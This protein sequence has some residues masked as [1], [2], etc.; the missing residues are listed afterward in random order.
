MKINR[1]D[2][3]VIGLSGRFPGAA[4]T[5]EFWDGLCAGRDAIRAL[6]DQALRAAGVA[7]AEL[8]DPDYVKAGAPLDGVELFDAGLFK[9]SPLEAE[10]MD[11]QIRLLL[12]C[13]WET[14]EDAGYGG[15]EPRRIGVFA[16]AGG[17][18][19]SYFSHFVN[20]LG[21]FEKITA[22]PTHLGND[23]DFL[24]TYLS[25]KLNLTGPSM[26]VQTACST[27]LVALHQ[28][29]LSLMAGECDMALAGG[30]SVRVPNGHGYRYKDGYI[31]SRSGRVRSFDA[32]ADG[33]VFG[34]GM[35]LVLIKRL[36]D[37]LR[38]GDPVRAVIKGSAI[39]NDGKGKMSYAASSARGQIACIRAALA[40]ACVEAG[41]IGLVEAHGTGTAMGDPEE[42]KALSAAFREDTDAKGYCALGAVKAN[43][44][45]LEAAAGIVGF[46]KAALAVERGV[47]PPLLHFQQA[48]PRIK[49][50]ATPFFVNTR[51]QPWRQKGPRRAAVN[52][53]GV[54]GT[55]AF[56]VLEQAPA[57]KPAAKRRA[58]A[59][60]ALVPIS[61]RSEDSLREYAARLAKFIAR[62]QADKTPLD[63]AE[64]ACTLQTG[65]E[66]LAQRAAFAVSS[67]AQ[68]RERLDAFA[69]GGEG[70]AAADLPAPAAQWLAEGSADWDSL[71]PAGRPRRIGLPTYVFARE[72]HWIDETPAAPARSMLHPLLHAN[73]SD[74]AEVRYSSLFHGDEF[75][76]RD[77]RVR[78]GEEQASLVLPGVAYL[79][80]AR[81]ALAQAGSGAQ[82][83]ELRDVVWLQPATVSGERRLD[84]ALI[85]HG[86]GRVDFETYGEPDTIHCQGRATA[87]A[88]AA[89]P[90][91]DLDAARSA[92]AQ[93]RWD[94]DAVYAA[95]AAMGLDYGPAHRPIAE[96]QR[97]SGE[98]LA[99]LRLPAAQEADAGQFGLHPSLLDGALQ[100]ATWLLIDPDDAP[101]RPLV[102]FALTSLRQYSALPRELYV[103]ARRAAGEGGALDLDLCDSD[104]AVCASLRG[105]LARPF[106]KSAHSSLRAT[107]VWQEATAQP[108]PAREALRTLICGLPQID[109]A[110]IDPQAQ[111]VALDPQDDQAQRYTALAQHC[112]AELKAVLSARPRSEAAFQVV[113]P[114]RVEDALLLGL[115][116]M[117]LSAGAENPR[118]RAQLIAVDPAIDAPALAALL[119]R[120]RESAYEPLLRLRAGRREAARWQLLPEAADAGA[121][122]ALA[123]KH[124]GTYLIT[125]GLGG[126]G[127][128]FARD[129]LRRCPGV[130][131]L[132]AGRASA[133][134]VR[135]SPRQAALDALR[136][137]GLQVEYVQLDLDD[138]SALRERLHALAARYGRIDG[139]VHSAGA[140]AD[141]L[142][143]T[144]P[145]D[146]LDAVLAPK[147]R[148][149]FNLDA[150]SADLD[151]DFLALFSS[152]S[153]ALGNAGQA[154]YAAA[155]G[156]LDEF[157]GQ[158]NRLAAAGARRGHT[159]AIAWP[160]WREGGMRLDADGEAALSA[161]TGVRPLRS[162]TGLRLFHRS[163]AEGRERV[164]VMDG[165]TAR[166]RAAL[167]LD[168]APAR[169]AAMVDASAIVATTPADDLHALAQR[170]LCERM[171]G[172]LKLPAQ[173]LDPAAPLED[174]GIDSILALDLTRLLEASFGALPRTLFFEYLSI[175]ELAGYFAREHADTL[176]RLDAGGAAQAPAAT[177]TQP[178]PSESAS[179]PS[180]ASLRRPA[181]RAAADA[182]GA[183]RYADEPIAIVGLSGRY[184]QAR[185]LD[186]FWRNLRDGRDCIEE[187]PASRWNWRDYYSED[188]SVPGRHYSKWG[189]FIEGVDEFDARFFNI[190]PIEAELLDP[191]ER[192]FLEHAWMAIEDAGLTRAALQI[193]AGDARAT[194]ELAGQVGVYAGVMYGEYQLI[195]VENSL[196]G[197][198][199]GFASNPA[200]V[201]NR[202]SYA[203][204]LHGPSMT[205]DTMCSSSLSA[206]HL[207]CQDLKL[208]RTDAA[209]AGGVNVT[210]HPNKYL[211]LSAGQFISGDGH[212]QSFGEGGD[213]YIPG[214]GVG[215]VVLKRLSDAQRDGNR[216]YGLIRGSALSH[217]GKT[218]G[219]TVPNPQAQ[220]S[221][222]RQA[223]RE[224]G[225]PARRIGYVEAHGTGT[226]LGDPIEIAAL[227]K[228]F[229]ESSGDSGFCLIGSAKSNIGHCEAAA[230]IA[231]LT[232]VLLQLQHGQIVP[233]LHSAQLNPHI[234]FAATPFVVNQGLREWPAPQHEGRALPRVAGISS[235]GAGGSN[236]HLIV[237]EYLAPVS[238]PIAD[239][240]QML[241]LSARTAEQ[242]R[243][244]AAD[245]LAWLEQPGREVVLADLAYTLQS[246]REA[247][248]ERLA[249]VADSP[250]QLRERL[251]AWLD[252]DERGVY[253]G[254]AKASRERLAEALNGLDL[255]AELPQWRER[256][257]HAAPLRLWALGLELDWAALRPLGAATRHMLALPA[258][259]FARQRHW[260]EPVAAEKAAA[261]V[262]ALHPLLHSNE[263][264]I[265]RCAY[266]ARFEGNEFFL[267][268]RALSEAACVE[269][270]RAAVA[271]ALAPS[272]PGLQL[273][274]RELAWAQPRQAPADGR[275]RISLFEPRG[276]RVRFEIHSGEGV[277]EVVHCQG[278]AVYAEAVQA[279]PITPGSGELTL[280]AVLAD[281]LGD[282]LLHPSLLQA[283]FA[284]ASMQAPLKLDSLSV[285]GAAATPSRLALRA[286]V[287]DAQAFDLDLCAADGRVWA[288]LRG[289]RFAATAAQPDS[290]APAYA[291]TS[292]AAAPSVAFATTAKAAPRRIAFAAAA[293]VAFITNT[294]DTA[295]AGL[296][297]PREIALASA[298][299][300]AGWPASTTAKPRV[301]L[302]EAGANAVASAPQP[303]SRED[304]ALFDEGQGV[305]VL[306][307]QGG[308][309]DAEAAAT[310]TQALRA[311][312][313]EPSLKTLLVLA[314][315]GALAGGA[316][317]VH[318]AALD[319]GLYRAAAEFPY[320]LIAALRGDADGPG[321]LFATLADVL[322]CAEQGRYA[323]ASSERRLPPRFARDLA[324]LRFGRALADDLLLRP[325]GARGSEL[326]QAGWTCSVLA[327]DAVEAQARAVAGDLAAKSASA[328]GLLKQELAAPLLEAVCALAPVDAA[329]VTS[330][331]ELATTAAVELPAAA[332]G[333]RA[334]SL[335]A[336]V[337][338]IEV[339]AQAGAAWA[340]EVR[341][342]LAVLAT[343]AGCRGIVLACADALPAPAEE[344]GR[345]A[346]LQALAE[347]LAALDCPVVAA[348]P[349]GADGAA[350]LAALLCDGVVYAQDAA[351]NAQ[352]LFD[353][354]ALAAP[355]LSVF[356]A[357]L[358][359]AP[360]RRLLLGGL[361]L[362]GAALAR[363]AQAVRVSPAS[364][365]IVEAGRLAAEL[366]QWPREELALW[367]RTEPSPFAQAAM[368]T[369]AD[370][371]TGDTAAPATGAID[372]DSQAI[373]AQWR[374]GGVLEIG[375][376]DRQSRN[377]FSPEFSRG[378]RAAFAHAES[379]AC[380][381]VVLGGFERYFAAGGTRE[382]L[383]AIHQGRAR[384]TDDK[385]FELPLRCPVPVI[386]AMQGH[387]VG[388][389]WALGMYADVALF[390]SES[391]YFSPY[392]GY[393]FTPGAGSTLLFAQRIGRDLAR[394][395]LLSAREYAGD[396][397]IARGLRQPLSARAQTVAEALALA[398]CIA[399]L[400]RA[401]LIALKRDWN[402]AL[403][404]GLEQAYA[405]ELAMH[406]RTFVGRADTLALIERSFVAPGEAT[407][408]PAAPAP[409]VAAAPLALADIVA[410]L[411][412]SLAHELRL[413]E[414]EIG[415]DEEF[416][417]LGLDSITGVTWIRRV[418][419]RYGTA[420]EAIQVYS[421]PTLERL[422]RHVQ[423]LAVAAPA[424]TSAPAPA[425]ASENNRIA[426]ADVAATLR[427]LLAEELRLSEQD[428][429]ADEP[430]VDL[431]LDSIT[432]VTWVRR[433]NERY[434]TAIEAVQV[435][436]HPNLAR[437][438]AFVA[439]K[440]GAAALPAEPVSMPA[441]PPA[442]IAANTQP[443]VEP[444]RVV[445]TAQRHHARRTTA[446]TA[447]AIAVIGMS[448][449]F[450]QARDLEQFW[451]NL[452]NARDCIAEVPAQRWDLA[453]YYQPG[454]AVPGKT[455][456]RW[457][458]A[459]EDYDRFDPAFF[460][461][462]PREARSMDPQQRLFLQACWHGIEHAGYNPKALAGSNCGVFVGCAAGDYHQLS[463]RE[464]LSG[465][466][467]TG[468]AP[469]ILAARISYFLDLHGPSLAVDT[470]CSSSLVALANACDSLASGA[471][472]LALAG[473]V[474]VMAGPGMHIMTAQVGMLG[475]GGRC[476]TFDAAADGIALGE[477][478]GV[479]VL[480]R[481]ADAERDGDCIHGVIEAW[482]VNQDGRS[483]GITA[484][485]ADAQARL[486]GDVYRRFG[487]DPAGIQ[488]VE[489]HGTGTALGDPIEVAALKTAFA[490]HTARSG[491]CALGSV[492]SNIGHCLSAAG[493]S[494]VLKLLLAL[495]HRQLPPTLH[496]SSLNPHI[497]LDGSPFYVNDRLREWNVEAGV[498][499][500]AAINAF[501]F[502]GTNAHAVISEYQPR[503]ADVPARGAVLAPLSAAT[504]EQLR[505]KAREL[506][507]RVEVGVEDLAS[508]AYTLQVGRE[509]MGERAAVVASDAA[510]LARGLRALAESDDPAALRTAGVLRGRAGTDKDTLA[511]FAAEPDFQR[512]LERW[513]DGGELA[514]L[515]E[516]WVKGLALD[517]PRFHAAGAPQRMALPLHPFARER[518]WIEAEDEAAVPAAT[519]AMAEPV[520]APAAAQPVRPV[521]SE[522]VADAAHNDAAAL[523][524]LQAQLR[525]SLAEA[526]FMRAAE[527]GLDKPFNELGLDSIVGVEWVKA[528]NQQ[529]GCELS[530]TRIYDYPSVRALAAY[531]HTAAP[532]AKTV[533]VAP[534]APV[535]AT[536]RMAPAA[537]REELR[538]SLAE[539]LFMRPA[540]IGWN[541][542]F[543]ELGLDSIVGVEWV[544][545]I[546]RRYG[547]VL[548]ATRVYDYP[549]ID[550]LAA[551]L[552]EQTGAAGVA[553]VVE[554]PAA[555]APAA[556]P[557]LE[558]RAADELQRELR[559]SLAE[560]LYMRP[561]D[562]GLDKS[563]TELGLDSIVGVEWM[564]QVNQRYGTQIAALRV[565]DYPSVRSLAAHL[566]EHLPAAPAAALR[567]HTPARSAEATADLF[568]PL[569][570][571]AAPQSDYFGAGERSGD[572]AVDGELSLLYR[573]VP[574]RNV[575]LREHVVFGRHLLPT[576]A[577]VELLLAAFAEHFGD[578]PA[579]LRDLALANPLLG[580]PGSE[581]RLRVTL[582]R[583]AEGLQCFVRSSADVDGGDETLHLS[584]LLVPADATAPV[585]LR[586]DFAV[587]R[588]LKHSEI[589]TN[590]GDCYAPLQELAFG[591]DAASGRIRS[592][593]I[594]SRFRADPFA[595]YGALC[596]AINAAG[597]IAAQRY[598]AHDDQF[599]PHRLGRVAV[600][601]GVAEAGELHSHAELR[602]AEADAL[603]FDVELSDAAGRVRARL[604]GLVLRRVGRAA[605]QR[606]DTARR[607]SAPSLPAPRAVAT[608]GESRHADKI[609]IVGMSCRFPMSEDLDTF[610]DNLAQGRDCI[611][612][613]PSQRW[614]GQGEW[615]HPDPRHPRTS[616]SKWAGLLD[617]IAA[618]DPLFFG[619]SPA[620]AELID[621][622]QRIFLEQC[623]K[624]IEHA[625]YAPGALSGQACGVYVGCAAG[626]Y[627]RVLGAAGQDGAGA[628]FMGTSSAILAARIAYFLNLKGAALAVDT[629]CS[630]SLVALHLACESI[631]SGENTWALC[632]GINL[633]TTPI[634]HVLTSQVG[635]PSRDG[636]CAAFDAS[637]GGIV[638]SEGC[639]VVLLK[640]L[641]QAQAD[642]DRILGVIEGSGINQDGK[643][644]GITA[645]SAQ[646]Q[647]RL[648]SQVYARHGIDPAQIGYVEAH[649]TAT[650]LGDPIEVDALRTVF[651]RAGAAAGGCALG[652][653]KSNIGHTGFAAGVAGVIKVL[654]CLQRRELVPTVHYTKANPHIRFEDSP[655]YVNTGRRDWRSDSRRLATVSSFGFSGTNA[656]VVI[657]EHFA[658]DEAAPATGPVLLPLSARSPAQLRAKAADLLA[659]LQREPAPDLHRLAYTL[660][661]GRDAMEHRLGCI[662][663]DAEQLRA[664]LQGWLDGRPRVPGLEHGRADGEDRTLAVFAA[665]EDMR[666]VFEQWLERGQLLKLLELW[667][668]GLDIDW[669]RL[670]R[671]RAPR[672]LSLPDYPF[673][674]ERC[675][676]Q[677]AA[678][679]ATG[680]ARARLHPLLH[681]NTSDLSLQ[682]YRSGFDGSEFFLADHRVRGRRVLPAVAQLEMAR[683]AFADA[684][685]LSEDGALL[686]LRHIAWAQ[687]LSVDGPCEVGIAVYAE[688]DGALGFEIYSHDADADDE[689]LHCQ[690]RGA[691]I[692][693][694]A[695]APLDL[696][697]LR[698]RMREG[699]SE[700]AALYPHLAG[701]GL[702]YG[703]AFQGVVAIE[704]GVGET[705]AEL[706]L[707][708]V[709]A[710]EGYVLHP[711]LLD[712]ALQASIPLIEA[713]SGGAAALPFALESLRGFAPCT[714]RMHAWVRYAADGGSESGPGRVIKVDI[715][716][717][718]DDGA[719]CVQMRGFASRPL[720]PA[721]L[722]ADEL[723]AAQA[724]ELG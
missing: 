396:E 522:V 516:L 146:A 387:A 45:H 680:S 345:L 337:L 39:G 64:L 90:R 685:P 259:P 82:T 341:R 275:Y 528:L 63:L 481:L 509:A 31:F 512:M 338:A 402:R 164:L 72:R 204:N 318:A 581:R 511:A 75:F 633:L 161:S 123:L 461:I 466:G 85:A 336:G 24:A 14:L 464:R 3:A 413:P 56:V 478:V 293:P 723:N 274:L 630:S 586:R 385:V 80:M 99:R 594:G 501:G 700:A 43:I 267:A 627:A 86:E 40:D 444:A 129:L 607:E 166:M 217:G 666:A 629:A 562:I 141:G 16:G 339:R 447:D 608:V 283:A 306:H 543:A 550:L 720:P 59:A 322:V 587:E 125:G 392:M 81:A 690:G 177:T 400:P 222:I 308:G 92:S 641:A 68:L 524:R 83:W 637:A 268:D 407:I 658:V 671:G 423:S 134:A 693:A 78:G 36:S 395:S 604:D 625:G 19:T 243:R 463:R 609:A 495:R 276:E 391:R 54:G 468:A 618:F 605:L 342:M 500:R 643:T 598:G 388:A 193:P 301:S 317:A 394:E 384:F 707:P 154:G 535:A 462:S 295:P 673:A 1:E 335:D 329:P 425:P 151:L 578:A 277:D 408:A 155:N 239:A 46:I 26:T 152:L 585:A 435:Y 654:L 393:G 526:L 200:S 6:D 37:A 298:V 156:F 582:R 583:H 126:L 65:R 538:D 490:A 349:A 280:P 646:A 79:E 238:A 529:L 127:L 44:G 679:A 292:V 568:A 363:E 264:G 178:V 122:T 530:A 105:F 713:A 563:F 343:S 313:A 520:A 331:S 665:D 351:Y 405:H 383:L 10:L 613:I 682:S 531:L 422:A 214:E 452:A 651:D 89:A 669:R 434:G 653:V 136:G 203:L 303:S 107:R 17:V 198:R 437:L 289:L 390:S 539:A 327:A 469:S 453:R 246:G 411:R 41:S 459:L 561:G 473:G 215:A 170:L 30:V 370:E 183:N 652:S 479:V 570:V 248:D 130:R 506:L 7:E 371:A 574:E 314:A 380:R 475:A 612:E 74:L 486:Q 624:A 483:N 458:G 546:N 644:N 209:I 455:N 688:D 269:M 218:N 521:A 20:R 610:W 348:L 702:Q 601:A 251:R 299:A 420:I 496:F 22:S 91:L 33:V 611:G 369:A 167:G 15:R 139:I 138:A 674:R 316:A 708:A 477:G 157:A 137:E 233:S 305:F 430:F 622:Q 231:G 450:A 640:S 705:L 97:G 661:V 689:I 197:K 417:A 410:E 367:K 13:A 565:Y 482:G 104:G 677:P 192:L 106:G 288:Q 683:A 699:R 484:P 254:Q 376:H 681:R 271:H 571:P 188:R 667:V 372:L 297:K 182:A 302:A 590:A 357:R 457:L 440:A 655:F 575:G 112:L 287:G 153:S 436:S 184:P 115:S 558:A 53:L 102:P 722:A 244:K 692:A 171:A 135:E 537:L 88:D 589:A 67:L 121:D 84:L 320:P 572:F 416:V 703:P 670:H 148:G 438:S 480:K 159:L 189:G 443:N 279:D 163:L 596:T 165:D 225:L 606:R 27:S 247:M 296:D 124:G 364:E 492:K 173:R 398:A 593:A 344:Q 656:H 330:E 549:S 114:D 257:E 312:A 286:A 645:P 282:Y 517:W 662:A 263:S 427:R 493:V 709:A 281:S 591:A 564:K 649:G 237:E 632:G 236:A 614:A 515:G 716:L 525:E 145:L 358:G 168:A 588:R 465:Q 354:A 119:Q 334:Y 554:A 421:H 42:V 663:A 4:D 252:G 470:A 718:G 686:E 536:P 235:F 290:N 211:M 373:S 25:Y 158:R 249:V 412:R 62:A 366:A 628:A 216:V 404:A 519:V 176:R 8:S 315:P 719:V 9:V 368:Q 566:L 278:V 261:R 424:V 181:L 559:D 207:A 541:K 542:S 431:G 399:R 262:D 491:Y 518:Y 619:I 48:N 60:P 698:Q 144:Q 442:D 602:R 374:P 397:L 446:P 179:R 678:S 201:A 724:V 497:A 273:Q 533:A 61:A 347:T 668:R 132:L 617:D 433:I 659:W 432:G 696:V 365:T 100:A 701:K 219:Y 11:P 540:D 109:P 300:E 418:N 175:A 52:S 195:G 584:G 356:A 647:E 191:Q 428:I 47:I 340:D 544:K 635:M 505:I 350:W 567:A 58:G 108:A 35:G 23:K 2:V 527:V 359:E 210:V 87:C 98:V 172:L 636:R 472:D 116:G 284:A 224:S 228:V 375:M 311:A 69:A 174:Y 639:G 103:V 77:H 687:P 32:G 648:L 711:S 294:T 266:A 221:A 255:A 180:T 715:D 523:E 451:D 414:E 620:E 310:L 381:A 143:A 307:L 415:A 71:Y 498:R 291:Q 213:G 445:L 253:R 353:D 110:A 650:A 694:P 332:E 142:I 599:L 426:A 232:K 352:D 38:D 579:A 196:R 150:A 623:W 503:P 120:E 133:E 240:A 76:L 615:F 508:L 382:T 717:C 664:Q 710:G 534:A 634:G 111:A 657:G 147:V 258:Y 34:S 73:T 205:V 187:V 672:R 50:D 162:A 378:L 194:Q 140:I 409:A 346:S 532:S 560:A 250:A 691:A 199:M 70:D 220:A 131:V 51:A 600:E 117:L 169:R 230:G 552:A 487:V 476:R 714:S 324:R 471:T 695:P 229:R 449:Q 18:G 260:I 5:A 29:R 502:S 485:N 242:L 595:L 676:V 704:R 494:G 323:L 325:H 499:R 580:E 507:A 389:G 488:L 377:M 553:A 94:H 186:A 406:E 401:R 489:A 226:K 319:A 557:Q 212:C 510:G 454:D 57:R 256:G 304:I 621:P 419:E 576:D 362:D 684:L 555:A 592:A 265:D 616:Y 245:L 573:I 474:N 333:I 12:Q 28:A 241:P 309:F 379:P 547:T 355:T 429:G 55:N 706:R 326:T 149:T 460:N 556:A 545:N 448:G 360:A 638:F 548:S 551:Y 208:G 66:T 631:R 227:T 514:R 49:F 712:S 96:L 113:V 660:Q 118:L 577:Y 675:W 721:A 328:L 101:E 597:H 223:L 569:A 321:L 190:A 603:E 202:V 513:I 21:R 185:D 403:E 361:R 697:A 439:E 95:F 128:V 285:L 93:Q 234:D 386:A 160:Y 206:I 642:N 467:F 272:R 626:D 456:S 504:P 441:S 270:A